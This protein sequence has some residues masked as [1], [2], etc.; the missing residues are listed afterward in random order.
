MNKEEINKALLDLV[1]MKNK[2]A[3]T[4]YD[5]E[6]YDAVEDE[7]HDLED[8][9]MDSHG[10]TFTD[11]LEDIHEEYCPED[12]V[13]HPIAYI[14]NKYI[15]KDKEEFAV[16]INDG[17]LV[18]VEKFNADEGRLVIIPNPIRVVLNLAKQKV[19]VWS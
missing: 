19:I 14:A 6:N 13:L 7:L 3:N 8:A 17:V 9:F 10:D 4:S 1:L 12:D 15:A 2:L 16:S 5:N 18:E 11:I